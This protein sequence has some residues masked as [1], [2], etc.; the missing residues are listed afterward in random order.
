MAQSRQVTK[1]MAVFA[2]GGIADINE[3]VVLAKSVE[4]GTKR[5]WREDLLVVDD[6]ER[7]SPPV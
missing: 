4:F 7:T 2:I 6:L 3:C 1:G 5:T